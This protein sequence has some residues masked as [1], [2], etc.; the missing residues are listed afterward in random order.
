MKD[1]KVNEVM[2]PLS[3]YATVSENDSL[4]TAVKKLKEARNDTK[5]QY[6]HR[7]V[8]VFDKNNRIIG[9]VSI[10]CIL[11]ALEPKY[12]HFQHPENIGSIGLSRFGFNNEFLTSLVENFSLWDETLEE[13]C[14]KAFKLKAKDIMYT[15]SNG[16]YVNEDS[17]IAEAVHQFILG[18]HQSLLVLKKDEVVGIIRLV[19]I[20]DLVCEIME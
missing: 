1:K 15:P 19:D 4:A 9:K 11:Q 13:L 18:C 2:I 5:Y 16:E 6:K 17:P 3:D 8:L 14:K 12:R 7:A 20:F 10:R